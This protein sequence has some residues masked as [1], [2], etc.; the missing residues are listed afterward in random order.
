MTIA[1]YYRVSPAGPSET[2]QRKAIQQWLTK[3]GINS[4]TVMWFVDKGDSLTGLEQLVVDVNNKVVKAIV[5]YSLGRLAKTPQ[6]GARILASLFELDVR[7]VATSQGIDIGGPTKIT[8][9]QVASLVLA[10]VEM[11]SE[12]R[13][14]KQN[15]GILAAKA[16]GVFKGR[17]RGAFKIEGG[18]QKAVSLRE[19]GLSND[20]IAV[21]LGLH[22]LTVVRYLKISQAP[23][24]I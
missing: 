17:K 13:R 1:C 15:V 3:L 24:G 4:S 9:K 2:T 23:A 12:L 6:D 5:V 19:Q 18:P 8:S 14:E 20:E 22:R 16:K 7:V 10:V 11:E 21:Q